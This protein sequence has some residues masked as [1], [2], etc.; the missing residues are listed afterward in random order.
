MSEKRI[1]IIDD[2]AAVLSVLKRSL[3]KLGDEYEV[4]TALDSQYALSQL[5]QCS[6]DLVI[7]DYKMAGMDG[8]ELLQMVRFIQPN[9]RTILMTAYGSDKVEAEACRLQTYRYLT[10]PLEIDNFR[11]IVMDA[12]SDLVVNRPA[13]FV[14]SDESYMEVILYMNRLRLEIGARCVVLAD[15]EGRSIAH[16]GDVNN[17]PLEKIV[18]LISGCITGLGEVGRV[19]DGEDDIPNLIYRECMT[20]NLYVI[21]VGPKLLLI[22][23]V[24]R[25]PYNSK[26]GTVW[27]S[28]QKTASS[29]YQKIG[30]NVFENPRD[31]FGEDSEKAISNDLDNL[32][33][34][35]KVYTIESNSKE[36]AESYSDPGV[37]RL[38]TNGKTESALTF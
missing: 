35:S 23:V 31:I 2:E 34:D 9:A 3:K 17:V 11:R 27:Y 4:F 16:T 37:H 33:S 28:A 10:K 15:T 25:G 18:P 19:L 30:Q 38:N 1:L 20:E 26:L 12:L 7:T 5:K 13:M 36:I 6:F 8:L 32:L 24:D 22:V 29:L 21:N 14:L